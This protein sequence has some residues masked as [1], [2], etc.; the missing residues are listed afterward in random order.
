MIDGPDM[1]PET[2]DSDVLAAEY[3]LGLLTG[4]A[5]RDFE[6]RLAREPALVAAVR[7]WEARFASLADEETAEVAPSARVKAGIEAELFGTRDARADGTPFWD[8]L[9]FWRGLSLAAT[10]VAAVAVFLMVQQPAAPPPAPPA[11]IPPGTILMSHLVPVEG[12]GLGLAVTREP[13]G[14]LRVLR[15]AG[16][17]VPGR[18]QEVWLVQDAATP[19]ISLG[20]LSDEPLTTFVPSPEVAALFEAGATVA[21]SEE[22]EGGSPTGAPTGPILAAGQLV[23]L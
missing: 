21:I 15:V 9:A 22:P 6:A 19:P 23:A 2:P 4:E 11:G 20:L 10:G 7:G 5:L 13:G 12:S 14:A 18:A 8:R 1:T 17:P 16:G 3:A